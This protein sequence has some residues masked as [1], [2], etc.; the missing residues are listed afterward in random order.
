MP[1]PR[2]H[3]QHIM[4]NGTMPW[5]QQ[6]PQQQQPQQKLISY[7]SDSGWVRGSIDCGA[8]VLPPSGNGGDGGGQ[9]RY[10]GVH[11]SSD[12][13]GGGNRSGGNGDNGDSGVGIGGGDEG[14]TLVAGGS[15]PPPNWVRR[16][17]EMAATMRKMTVDR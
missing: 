14:Y 11:G 6:D 9:Q 13:S 8:G 4:V 12:G 16:N 10:I 15:D 7:D 2:Q 5:P 3:Q 1:W 17:K